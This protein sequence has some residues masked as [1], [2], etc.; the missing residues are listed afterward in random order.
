MV[1]LMDHMPP[2]LAGKQYDRG[3]YECYEAVMSDGTVYA[4]FAL[5]YRGR[6][7]WLYWTLKEPGVKSFRQARRD[8]GE[9][10]IMARAAGAKVL[11]CATG[12]HK[13]DPAFIREAEFFG[14]NVTAIVAG[15][16]V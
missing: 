9:A 8:I 1:R 11:V 10:K 2:E 12:D 4:H 14:F 3:E 7:A 5:G 16:E 6:E 15:M 13:R